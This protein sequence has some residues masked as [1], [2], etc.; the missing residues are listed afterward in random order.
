MRGTLKLVDTCTVMLGIIPAYAGNIG[1][2]TVKIT[3]TQNHPRVCGEHLFHRVISSFISESSPRMRGTSGCIACARR[4]ARIIP[5]YAGN[6]RGTVTGAGKSGNHPR[7]CGEHTKKSTYF[8]AFPSVLTPFSFNFVS[9]KDIS[10]DHS[11]PAGIWNVARACWRKL[12]Y[13][14]AFSKSMLDSVGT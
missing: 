5:A 14:L 8:R 7:V 1:N 9:Y 10:P 11:H 3:F 6:I 2:S 13:V 12:N 4:I